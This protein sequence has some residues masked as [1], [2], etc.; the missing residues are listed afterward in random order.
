VN[1]SNGVFFTVVET[2]PL[3]STGWEI[4]VI[5]A[6]DFRN[7]KP[8]F[9]REVQ[10]KVPFSAIVPLVKIPRFVE[11]WLSPAISEVGAGSVTLDLDDPMWATTLS[12]GSPASMLLDHEH[13]WQIY[14]DGLLRFEFLG[15]Q[16]DAVHLTPDGR[17]TVTISGK[18]GAD[19]LRWMS[20]TSP[21]FPGRP[22]GEFEADVYQFRIAVMD[23]YLALIGKAWANGF[24][25]WVK[26]TW[27]NLYDSAGQKWEDAPKPPAPI[28]N[29][30]AVLNGDVNFFVGSYE[31]TPA[32]QATLSGFTAAFNFMTAPAIT[33]VG[34]TDSTSSHAFN[35]TLSEQRA[36]AAANYIKALVP[37]AVI[38]WY[39]K[40]ETQP[41][42]TNETVWGREQN[43]RV[44]VTYPQGVMP[45]PVPYVE[46]RSGVNYLDLLNEWT[47][48]N[49][50]DVAP[51]RAEWLMHPGFTLDV[52]KQF[53]SRRDKD[54]IFYEGSTAVLSKERSR[55]SAEI[56]N[57]VAI[58]CNEGGY[59][60]ATDDESIERW[61]RRMLFD[62]QKKFNADTMAN[63][64]KV[65]LEQNKDEKAEWT[66]NVSPNAPGRRIFRDYGLGDWVGISRFMGGA[67]TQIEPFR[68]MGFTLKIDQNSNVALELKLQSARESALRRLQIR[69][70]N[71]LNGRESQ[72]VYVQDEE[73]IYAK[74]GDIWTPLRGDTYW[75]L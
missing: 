56:G 66:I 68:V 49:I 32:A 63:I 46:A 72:N 43:R 73:P 31:L 15:Q 44:T 51:I 1:R 65:K 4:R 18:G 47:G 28:D 48:Q 37:Q 69:L 29:V 27:T 58:Q 40:G 54:V 6:K 22:P 61:N 41:I 36:Q 12:D 17:R 42:A 19:C 9:T 25:T 21:Y 2:P 7:V 30:T 8:R 57:Y 53:G 67:Q 52:R 24:L 45:D 39:G 20:V 35:Q 10:T 23:A 3:V 11:A 34:H 74:I 38:T 26:P 64:A 13:L 59:T 50:D 16:R 5:S 33:I 75:Q 14:E 55:N 71:L 62:R 70:T 60:I